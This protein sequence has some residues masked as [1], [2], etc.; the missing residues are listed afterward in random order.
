[1]LN[2]ISATDAGEKLSDIINQVALASEPV[3]LTMSGKPM[4]A[5][6]SLEDLQSFQ[7]LE[8]EADIADALKAAEEPGGNLT[9]E[10]MRKELEAA[11]DLSG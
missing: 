10:Q 5:I 7:R 11:D 8:D 3:I 1:M 9:A 2:Q 6:V 4:A